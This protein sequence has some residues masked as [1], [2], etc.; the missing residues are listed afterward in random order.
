LLKDLIAHIAKA[1]VDRPSVNVD[2]Q[3]HF[4]DDTRISLPTILFIVKFTTYLRYGQKRAAIFQ[5]NRVFR[6]KE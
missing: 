6:S 2:G 5:E 4:G 3:Y 1:I